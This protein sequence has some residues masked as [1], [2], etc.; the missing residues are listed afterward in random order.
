MTHE[1]FRKA[2]QSS[3]EQGQRRLFDEY[4]SYV[5]AIVFGRL[6]SCARREDIEEC[7]ED[8]FADIYVCYDAEKELS[9]DLSGFIG[10][11]ARRRAIDVFN[12]LTSKTPPAVSIDS[13]E[14]LQLEAPED[15]EETI[16]RRELRRILISKIDELGEPD[17]V[18]I[19]QKYFYGRTAKE[20]SAVVP[21]TPEAIRVRSGRAVR[22]L[23][24]KLLKEG[25]S[26]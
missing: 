17:S 24:E 13:V 23:K 10:A 2:M 7:V 22:R 25:I 26:L 20:I 14:A 12:R 16:D 8:V 21:L 11:V 6:R 18:I 9:G 5:Y 15:T 4:F 1:D 3:K 19:M